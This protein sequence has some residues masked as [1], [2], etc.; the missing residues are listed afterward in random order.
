[1]WPVVVLVRAATRL[2][3]V[4]AARHLR[5]ATAAGG[6]VAAWHLLPSALVLGSWTGARELPGI[7]RWRGPDRP[8][9]RTGRGTVAITFDDGPSEESTPM[10]LDR[11]DELGL[12]ATF[13]CLGAMV[14]RAPELVMEIQ[15]RGHAVGTHGYSHRPHLLRSPAWV[16]RDLASAT[17]S[18]RAAGITPRWFRPPYGVVTGST[19][20]AARREHLEVVL[21][22][23][24]GREWADPSAERVL[25]RIVK[26]I[27]PGSIVLLHDADTTSPPGTWKITHEVLGSLADQL[28]LRE[29]DA[30]TLDTLIGPDRR[31]RT[32]GDEARLDTAGK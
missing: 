5:Q 1:M 11:L 9:A 10:I 32:E 3:G 24:W 6:A 13:F 2:A 19:L 16:L 22:S 21:W 31:S 7:C 15:R 27:G 25:A 17:G 28:H 12:C 4:A 14:D 30:V 23:S 29:L 8:H 26:G 18:L 20:L